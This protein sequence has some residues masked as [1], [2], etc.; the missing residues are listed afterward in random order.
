MYSQGG[1]EEHWYCLYQTMYQGVVA[2]LIEAPNHLPHVSEIPL[3]TEL[4]TVDRRTA[5]QLTAISWRRPPGSPLARALDGQGQKERMICIKN[6][7]TPSCALGFLMP[8][9]LQQ[10]DPVIYNPPQIPKVN[11]PRRKQLAAQNRYYHGVPKLQCPAADPPH[12]RPD[13]RGPDATTPE[14]SN[15][16]HVVRA[17]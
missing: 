8:S 7:I 17:L 16:Q 1:L 3:A 5:L 9:S 10:P 14:R 15:R 13:G 12:P 4:D 2:R 6:G 11:R